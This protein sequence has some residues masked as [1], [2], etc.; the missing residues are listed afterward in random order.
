MV[1]MTRRLHDYAVRMETAAEFFDSKWSDMQRAQLVQSDV[2]DVEARMYVVASL[3]EPRETLPS[4][5][6]GIR[7]T[8]DELD[9]QFIGTNLADRLERWND[10]L[11]SRID[12]VDAGM[13][14]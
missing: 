13:E 4:L 7:R 8:D 5:E 14:E 3:T 9:E 12:G 6:D 10:F 2:W 1:Q 11:Q